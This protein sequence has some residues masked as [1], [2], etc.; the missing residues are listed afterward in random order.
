LEKDCIPN[1]LKRLSN[2]N[3]EIHDFEKK[4]EDRIGLKLWILNELQRHGLREQSDFKIYLDENP[5]IS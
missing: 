4:T 1:L 2:L 5:A 3:Y